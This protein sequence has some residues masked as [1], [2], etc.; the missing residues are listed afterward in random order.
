MVNVAAR[1]AETAKGGEVLLTK[2]VAQEAE[3][4]RGVRFS[5]PRGRSYKGVGE[6]VLVCR[7]TRETADDA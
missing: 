6:R 7:A 4:L 2:D 3:G 1:A 5:R